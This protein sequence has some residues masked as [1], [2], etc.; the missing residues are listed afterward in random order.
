MIILRQSSTR[1]GRLFQSILI[2][3]L[4][5]HVMILSSKTIVSDTRRL[6]EVWNTEI[7]VP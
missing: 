6:K 7:V 4:R 2:F 1:I 5:E 3:V